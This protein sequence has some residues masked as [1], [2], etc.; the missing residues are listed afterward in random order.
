M[1]WKQPIY[2]RTMQDIYDKTK[3]AYLNVEDLNRIEGNI[4]YIGVMMAVEVETKTWSK[5]SLPTAAD[6]VRI[7]NNIAKLKEHVD[8]TTYPDYPSVPINN[9][10]KINTI[11]MLL[12]SIQGDYNIVTGAS[13]FCD[14]GGYAGDIFI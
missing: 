9:F 14:D 12:E 1:G 10:Q 7:G 8:Y 4:A 11:E 6:F 3:K 2:D 5:T 13:L